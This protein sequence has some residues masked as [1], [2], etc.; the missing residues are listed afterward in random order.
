MPLKITIDEKN[1]HSQWT[2]DEL[3]RKNVT[4]E[5]LY[6]WSAPLDMIKRYQLYLDRS[7]TSLGREIFYNCTAQRFGPLCQY[8]LLFNYQE[9]FSLVD[10]IRDFQLVFRFES[11]TSF[12]CYIHLQC[13]RGGSSV[14]LDWSEICDGKIDYF[15][16]GVDEKDCWQ[17]EANQCHGV[18]EY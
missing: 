1:I 5:Q 15:S 7:S 11:T 17:L 18:D 10:Y 3:S 6:Y 4:G 12:T 16:D 14:C 13:Q 9:N 2:F 8:Y